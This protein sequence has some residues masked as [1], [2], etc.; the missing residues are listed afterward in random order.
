MVSIMSGELEG[1]M[2]GIGWGKVG[3]D[4]EIMGGGLGIDK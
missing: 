3:H 4:A 2:S 1:G